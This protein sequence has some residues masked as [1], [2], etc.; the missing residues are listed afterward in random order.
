MP[1]RLFAIGDI[2]GCSTALKTLI[3]AIDPRPDDTIV[4]LGD[5]VDRGPDSAGVVAHLIGPAPAGFCRFSLIGNHE[6][7]M[8]DFLRDPAAHAY[9]LDEGG[10][11][12]LASSSV[13]TGLEGAAG[14]RY[15]SR[16]RVAGGARASVAPGGVTPQSAK[17]RVAS[18]RN[19]RTTTS[20][21]VAIASTGPTR[22]T[23]V[24]A[25]RL[26]MNTKPIARSTPGTRKG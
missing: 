21:P 18:D 2:H 23:V 6:V 16:T 12:T 1:N 17:S 10:R 13:G 7:M 11:E 14:G 26:A 24:V 19:I 22:S 25:R 4:T 9:W 8:L 15:G 3:D 5:Y 20:T